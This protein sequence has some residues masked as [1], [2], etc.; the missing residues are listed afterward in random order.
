MNAFYVLGVVNSEVV[1]DIERGLGP[2]EGVEVDTIDICIQQL[3]TLVAGV[4][5]ADAFDHAA[6]A[7]SAQDSFKQFGGEVGALCQ[8]SHAV[9]GLQ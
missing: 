9:Q 4:V 7:T 1:V 6:L 3:G 8:I 5:R 2:V